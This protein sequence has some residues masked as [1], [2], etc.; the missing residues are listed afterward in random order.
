MAT[1]FDIVEKLR[2]GE[3]VVIHNKY[4]GVVMQQ[5]E[6]HSIGDICVK[7]EAHNKNHTKLTVE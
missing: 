4:R 1:V 2:A 7:F 3:E 6:D 5:M